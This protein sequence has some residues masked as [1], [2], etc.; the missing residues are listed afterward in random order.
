MDQLDRVTQTVE[1]AELAPSTCSGMRVLL[2]QLPR[3][4]AV[5]VQVVGH[6]RLATL[7][8]L[9]RGARQSLVAAQVVARS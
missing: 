4:V 6:H 2:R 8:Q 1:V 7:V 5:A 9:R 3:L